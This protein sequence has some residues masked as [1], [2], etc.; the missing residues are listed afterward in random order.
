MVHPVTESAMSTL[1]NKFFKTREVV[2]SAIFFEADGSK[3]RQ[4]GFNW[5]FFRDS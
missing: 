1:G 5:D 3:L 2:I 4:M